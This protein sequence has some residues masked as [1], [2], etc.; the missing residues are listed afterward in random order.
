MG[1]VSALTTD[2]AYLTAANNDQSIV[3]YDGN[4]EVDAATSLKVHTSAIVG[5][6]PTKYNS[7]LVAAGTT[8]YTIDTAE[9]GVAYNVK[10]T[11]RNSL[12]GYG[13]ATAVGAATPPKQ[14]PGPP[15]SVSTAV[16]PGYSD[17]L[18]VSWAPPTS[19]G[20][21]DILRYRVE[22][23]ETNTFDS[24]V[25]TEDFW[26]PT[27]N[28][29]TVWQVTT[30]SS[31]ASNAVTGGYFAL[32]VTKNGVTETTDDIPYNAVALAANETGTE[33]AIST[34]NKFT[35]TDGTQTINYAG[36]GLQSLLFKGDKLRFDLQDTS[37]TT[38]ANYVYDVVDVQ[39][40][41]ATVYHA[42]TTGNGVETQ[43]GT[44]QVAIAKRVYGGR[45]DTTTSQIHCTDTDSTCTTTRERTSGSMQSKLQA[46]T[47]VVTNGVVVDRDGPDTNGGFTWRITFLDDAPDGSS[48]FVVTVASETISSS[49]S[50]QAKSNNAAT[51][52]GLVSAGSSPLVDG[53][54]YTSCTGTLKTPTSGGLTKGTAYYARVMAFSATGYSAPQ[55]VGTAVAPTVVPGAPTGVT[56]EVV[57]TSSTEL[58]VLFSPPSDNGGA[59][60]EKYLIE[61]DTS[62]A[63]SSPQTTEVTYL[64]G[65][66][67]FFKTLTGLT[68]GTFYFVR[69]SAYNKNGY[70]GTQVTTPASLNPHE[71]PSAPT[72]V[73]LSVTSDS[74]LTVSWAAPT[75]NGG[76]AISGYTCEWDTTLGFNSGSL[77]PHKGTVTVAA[78]YTSTTVE[79]LSASSTYYFRCAARNSMGNGAYQTSSPVSAMPGLQVPGSPHSIVLAAGSTSG[80]ISISWQR[81]KIP[82]HGIPCSGSAASPLDCPTPFGSSVPESAGGSSITSYEIE[83]SE[84]RSFDG[85]DQAVSS[86]TGTSATLT[87]LTPGRIYFI[88]IFAKNQNGISSACSTDSTGT[89]V[90]VAATL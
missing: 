62:S 32:S 42:S 19:D 10:V 22:L 12:Y 49:G 51:A 66:S 81:P 27:A 16:N 53:V 40:S 79:L 61:Y 41:S 77:S 15:L 63:F 35:I 1:D 76:D 67:P 83:Y 36:T 69:V 47:N 5:E 13:P 48:D 4:N 46:L 90:S 38:L 29:R 34:T 14:V 82:H 28:V 18:L 30:S 7:A 65:G 60:I 3:V 73:A 17:S 50:T 87:G 39:D 11:A 45:G 37:T 64:G 74:M 9:T 89:Q 55:S 33:T 21:D 56:L 86:V 2:V 84:R 68:A 24:P 23:D 70:G 72:N 78:T 75:S 57:E 71:V 52:T 80:S 44:T 6:T 26:C 8:S 43:G 58:K 25:A 20:G 31:S 54:T 85:Q 59:A 88:R